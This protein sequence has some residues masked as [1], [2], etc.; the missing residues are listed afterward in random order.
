MSGG[1]G[2]GAKQ[3]LLSLDPET[4]YAQSEQDDIEGFIKAFQERNSASPSEGIIIPGSYIIFCIEPHSTEED[5]RSHRIS[6]TICLG[7]APTNNEGV[8]LSDEP[9]Q[10][11]ITE[12]HF[13]AASTAG[14]FLRMISGAN[15]SSAT[16]GS[17]KTPRPF[18]T[19]IN[20][21]R[22][23]LSVGVA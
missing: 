15:E 4:S 11:K 1:G 18:T 8:A 3:G 10:V 14:L 9:D 6:P 20:V 22:A 12:D 2:W 16:E 23:C 5:M 17:E 19:K 7:V 13:G 21:P